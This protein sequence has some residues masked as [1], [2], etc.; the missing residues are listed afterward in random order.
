MSINGKRVVVTGVIA[1]ESRQTAERKL[2]EEGA[3]VQSSVG[4][5]TDLLVTGERVGASK[6]AKARA[7]GITVV[8][9][10]ALWSPVAAAGLTLVEA[11]EAQE[12]VESHGEPV[13][14]RKAVRQ[15][16]PMLAK[17]GDLPF[18]EEALLGGDWLYEIKWD[19][20]RCTATI[21]DGQV[22]M[23][24]RSGKSE[25]TAKFP[26]IAR[27]L[28]ELE[29]CIL[30]GELVVLN[31]NGHSEPEALDDLGKRRAKFMVFDVL[32]VGST[33]IRSWPL[34]ARKEALV[35][36]FHDRTPTTIA[37]SPSFTDGQA[38]L[39][40]CEEL[41]LE[42]LVAKRKSS[43]YR[44]GSKNGD[45]IKVKLRNEQEF[46]VVGWKPG[47]GSR[48]G[49]AGSLLLAVNDPDRDGT[50]TYCG[51]VGTGGDYSLWESFTRIASVD[52]PPID[53]TGLT[54]AF[55]RDVTW[56]VPL[57]VV[58]VKFQRWTVDGRLFHPSLLR[59]RT[60]KS[61]SEVRRDA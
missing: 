43:I 50:F 46:V 31:G 39:D 20:L 37:L 54:N 33:D 60:D 28:V 34:E 14:S 3:L 11:A 38:L 21:R 16:G 58:Q 59:V 22:F 47:E 42:G 9:W 2:R 23:Q 36:M 48:D 52:H 4:K 6:L 19:G 8:S 17:A 61:A 18:G 15:I 53:T 12:H 51:R 44:E 10:E 25:Y 29:D 35:E 45:W 13:A 56:L 30:D 5:T 49:A 24:S 1:G 41:G 32:E 40:Y 55:L 57:V 7:A 27:E 26:H